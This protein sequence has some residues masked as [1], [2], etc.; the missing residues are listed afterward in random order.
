MIELK[1]TR[2]REKMRRAGRVVAEVLEILR[3]SV[4]AGI[5]TRELDQIAD[6]EIRERGGI[7]VFKGYHGYP[8]SV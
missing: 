4:R 1:S 2:D 7:P 3:R 6:Q 8:A 5:P